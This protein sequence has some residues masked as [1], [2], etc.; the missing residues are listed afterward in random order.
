MNNDYRKF[1][2]K[3]ERGIVTYEDK[4]KLFKQIFENVG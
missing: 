3:C 2:E 4:K 1:N